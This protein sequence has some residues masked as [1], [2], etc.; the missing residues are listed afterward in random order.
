P[1]G[2]VLFSQTGISTGPSFTGNPCTLTTPPGVAATCSVTFS[3]TSTG[4]ASITG[5]YSGDTGYSTSTSTGVAV[6]VTTTAH[7]TTTTILCSPNPVLAGVYST[8]TATVTDS[9]TSVAITPTRHTNLH[10]P[11][12]PGANANQRG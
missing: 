3:S 9:S 6:T 11:A 1:T 2:T 4:V 7:A 8:C 10:Y 12:H 5:V